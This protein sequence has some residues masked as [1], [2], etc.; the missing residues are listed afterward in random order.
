MGGLPGHPLPAVDSVGVLAVAT[1]PVRTRGQARLLWITVVAGLA[2]SLLRK[3][4]MTV[5]FSEAS[6]AMVVRPLVSTP[7]LWSFPWT[8]FCLATVSKAL[9]ARASYVMPRLACVPG[10]VVMPKRMGPV[11]VGAAALLSVRVQSRPSMVWFATTPFMNVS[12][13]MPGRFAA[14][15]MVRVFRESTAV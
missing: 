10:C 13:C 11:P 6:G 2:A 15:L 14:P 9:S 8:V 7:L 5:G 1:A 4:I 3:F 12:A